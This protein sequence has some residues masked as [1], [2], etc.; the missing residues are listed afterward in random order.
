[1]FLQRLSRIDCNRQ[2]N[3]VSSGND[4]GGSAAVCRQVSSEGTTLMLRVVAWKHPRDILKNAVDV[5]PSQ[6]PHSLFAPTLLS[7]PFI[8]SHLLTMY[9]ESDIVLLTQS[10]IFSKIQ[11][12]LLSELDQRLP[13][14]NAHPET[15]PW[16]STT[17]S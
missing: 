2:S 13:M 11:V 10:D 15:Q 14:N 16:W 9:S 6:R 12:A 3:I 4:N 5:L 8:T 17:I 7:W 1:M